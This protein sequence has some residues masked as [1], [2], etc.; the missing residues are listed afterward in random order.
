MR[1]RLMLKISTSVFM[2]RCH[3]ELAKEWFKKNI[4]PYLIMAKSEEKILKK[5]SCEY[6]ILKKNSDKKMYV[7]IF[8]NWRDFNILK[9]K[10]SMIF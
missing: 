2:S 5:N 6:Q 9:R 3:M 8:E 10:S 7:K 1:L 4:L